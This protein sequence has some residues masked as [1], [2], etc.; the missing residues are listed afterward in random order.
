MK[1]LTL[2]EAKLL[3]REPLALLWGLAMPMV[4]L[5]VMGWSAS[6]IGGVPLV[7]VYEPIVIAFISVVFGVQGIPVQV[8]AYRERRILRR[9][10]VTPAGPVRVIGA[11]LI[12]SLAVVL[13]AECMDLIDSTVVNVAAPPIARDFHASSTVLEWIV[14][15]YPLAISVGLILGG[16]LGD[17]VGRRIMFLIGCAGFV[18]ASTLSSGSPTAGTAYLL[19]GFAAAF[20]GATQLKHGRFNAF[21]TLIAVLL[22]GTGTVGLGLANAPQWAADM[23]VG[24]VLIASLAMTGIQSRATDAGEGRLQLLLKRFSPHRA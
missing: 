3:A 24:V 6:S 16:R 23:F 11:Q 15:G 4:L 14:S 1:T 21:G 12:V 2:T 13:A 19:P 5:A 9:L 17:L 10:A 7:T 20:L 18:L 22:L 8:A